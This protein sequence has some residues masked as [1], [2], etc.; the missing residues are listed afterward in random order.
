MT[1]ACYQRI[2]DVIGL[3]QAST[4]E[5]DVCEDLE[6]T[7]KCSPP[8]PGHTSSSPAPA[9]SLQSALHNAQLV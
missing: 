6:N 8:N 5:A 2:S 1:P 7:E 9:K 4:Q 3:H